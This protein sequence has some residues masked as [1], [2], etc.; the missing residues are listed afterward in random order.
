MAGGDEENGAE[1]DESGGP[2][3]ADD[4][5]ERCGFHESLLV[6]VL[7]FPAL[8]T[9]GHSAIHVQRCPGDEGVPFRCE[10]RDGFRD[11]FRAAHTR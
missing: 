3:G 8:S 6:A 11:V 7:V 10:K 9:E 4:S 5:G 1:P 2:M